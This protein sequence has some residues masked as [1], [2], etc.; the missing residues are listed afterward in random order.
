MTLRSTTGWG[1]SIG[2]TFFALTVLGFV[3][4]QGIEAQEE[5]VLSDVTYSREIAPILQRSCQNCH[6]SIGVA[7]MALET[8]E[9]VRRYGPR[10]KRRTGIRDRAGAMPPWYVEKDIGIQ[11]FKD[12]PSLSDWELAAVAAWV[13]NGMPEGDPADLPEPIEWVSRGDL[14]QAGEPDLVVETEEIFMEAGA[15]D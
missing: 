10:I 1:I 3:F 4:A 11:H 13:D 5:V 6:N 7:P 2:G 15:P 14:W 12:D 9:Q 8:Y